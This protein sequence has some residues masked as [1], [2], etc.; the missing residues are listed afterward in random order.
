MSLLDTVIW[1]GGSSV[2]TSFLLYSIIYCKKYF[3]VT[4]ARDFLTMGEHQQKQGTPTMGGLAFYAMLPVLYFFYGGD[5]KF[6][7][8]ALT[9]G[10]SG[11]VGGVDDWCKISSG[12]GLTV[13][14]KFIVQMVS[15][16]CS[17]IFFY[18]RF[19]LETYVAIFGYHIDLGIYYIFWI[20][21]VIMAT[22]HAVNLIDGIDGLAISQIMIIQ[23]CSPLSLFSPTNSVFIVLFWYQ[24]FMLNRYKAKIFMGDIGAFFLGGYLA[25]SFIVARSE[26]LLVPVGIVLVINTLMIIIQTIYYKKYRKRFFSFTPYHHALEKHGWS[27]N[28]ICMVYGLLTTI[29][30][31]IGRVLYISYL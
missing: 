5:V 18:Y 20:V 3:I 26:I 31:L 25:A 4:K 11:I 16:F 8:I 14:I 1:V 17:A 19:P 6:W 27:E 7:F 2:F 22:T 24:F 28:K 9:A 13:K 12:V 21:W 23:Y 30:S 15:A 29:G 10:L